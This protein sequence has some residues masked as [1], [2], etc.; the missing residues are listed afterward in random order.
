ML[1]VDTK[2]GPREDF[3]RHPKQH[4]FL[5]K[6]HVKLHVQSSHV[7]ENLVL[8]TLSSQH[9]IG[10]ELR[11]SVAAAISAWHVCDCRIQILGKRFPQSRYAAP[12]I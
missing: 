11:D 12:F 3:T 1:M 10:S 8:I 4:P 5:V 9:C 2:G 7:S 6:S